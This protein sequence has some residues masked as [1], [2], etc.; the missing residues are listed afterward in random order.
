M[1]K[2][3]KGMMA[4][5]VMGLA[6]FL[7]IFGGTAAAQNACLNVGLLGGMAFSIADEAAEDYSETEFDNGTIYGASLYYSPSTS[8][9]VGVE[10]LVERF[11]MDLKEEGEEFGS[12]EMT[13]IMV[14]FKY[15]GTPAQQSSF[16]GHADIGAGFAL[17]SFDKGGFVTDMENYYGVECDVDTDTAFVFTMGAGCDFFF[18]PQVSLF[19]D[20]RFVF[21]NVGTDWTFSGPAGQASLDIDEFKASTIQGLIGLRFWIK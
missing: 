17:T 8:S 14:L 9:N 5:F 15:Q 1:I 21:A 7:M 10:L 16:T 19:L 6:V 11:S 12:L 20:G 3:L 18:T 4:V 13:P 2:G